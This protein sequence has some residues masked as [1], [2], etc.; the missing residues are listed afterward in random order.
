MTAAF[1]LPCIL[2]GLA[3][4]LIFPAS[5]EESPSKPEPVTFV[6]YNLKN[7]LGMNRRVKGELVENAGKPE[8]EI[9]PLIAA[10][11]AM[12]PDILGV[13]ELGDQTF[14]VDLKTRL[15]KAGIDLP[16]TE[17]VTAASGWD[18]N[19]GLLSR[20]PIV[21]SHSRDDLA[22]SIGKTRLPFQRGILDVTIEPNKDYRLRCVGLHLKSKLTVP[23]ADQAE[24]RRNEAH[25]ARKHIDAIFE[26]NPTVNLLVYGDFNDY[27]NELPVK[28]IRGKYRS[29][30]YL[31]DLKPADRFG[32]RWTHHWSHQ[33]LYARIDFTLVSDGLSPEIDR[34]RC[35]I[36][37]P[38]NWDDA[39]DHRPMV[40]SLTPKEVI[41]NR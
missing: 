34:D 2:A 23:E 27:P 9:A 24:M 1:R 7:Y 14:M 35:H 22:Y 13:C 10:I 29:P 31:T 18:R 38:E 25:L 21:E 12:K 15:K 19:L 36:F 3:A 4:A 8:D 39:S 30:G 11:V 28:S 40:I 37:H 5:A 33:D 16:H 20:F 17:L 26:A 6:A 41:R 32:F